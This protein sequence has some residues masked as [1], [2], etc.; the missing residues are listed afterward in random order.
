LKSSSARGD[1]MQTSVL[2][3]ED[4][5]IVRA[6]VRLSLS[7][8][9]F[10]V[11]G[12][13]TTAA[14]ALDLATRRRPSLF[15]VDYHLPDR[16]GTDLV[17]ELRVNGFRAPALLITAHTEKGLN[18]A[19][20]EAGAQGSV[21]KSGSP[22]ALLTALRTVIEG[23][24]L[25]DP[26]HPRRPKQEVALSPREREV[27]RLVAEGQT[28]RNI[29]EVLGVGETTVKTLLGRVYDKLGVNRRA[30]AVA[31]AHERGLL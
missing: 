27:L 20:R 11:A 1:N 30:Q 6:W 28:T 17:K 31:A 15:L 25:F 14:E 23:G 29:A 9:E 13:A 18:E 26:Q 3:I 24:E 21:I 22:D 10:R 7:H 5:S 12:E 8:S 2:L 4:D 16:L 19:A